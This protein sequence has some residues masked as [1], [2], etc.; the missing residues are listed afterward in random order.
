MCRAAD[1]LG[2]R[3][4]EPCPPEAGEWYDY[5]VKQLAQNAAFSGEGAPP[6][7]APR[8]RARPFQPC[9]A[10]GCIDGY[11]CL[12]DVARCLP[13]PETITRS[14]HSSPF[15]TALAHDAKAHHRAVEEGA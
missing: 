3:S 10:A 2:T 11:A 8:A 15:A 13:T 9:A 5:E 6:T 14:A 1:A 4:G 7:H 12:G